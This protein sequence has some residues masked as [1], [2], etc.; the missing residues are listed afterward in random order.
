MFFRFRKFFPDKYIFFEKFE[1]WQG[2]F[3]T[4]DMS[5]RV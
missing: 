3:Y 1:K 4:P 5:K 2:K